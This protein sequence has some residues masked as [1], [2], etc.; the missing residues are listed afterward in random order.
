MAKQFLKIDGFDE[1]LTIKIS[2]DAVDFFEESCV[3]KNV[4]PIC[5]WGKSRMGKSTFLNVLISLLVDCDDFF[6]LEEEIQDVF[7]SEMT[8]GF[9]GVTKSKI[10][11]H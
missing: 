3:N 9:K 4:L 7:S 10:T 6:N 5:I 2:D 11:V 8:D 1:N